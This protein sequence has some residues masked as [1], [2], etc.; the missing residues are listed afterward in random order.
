MKTPHTDIKPKY[1]DISLSLLGYSSDG[2]IISAVAYLLRSNG[3]SAEE[4][5]EFRSEATS[6]DYYTFLRTVLAWVRVSEFTSD[7]IACLE[8]GDD[9]EGWKNRHCGWCEEIHE[10]CDCQ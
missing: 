8:Q 4:I 3:V 6:D 9:P 5:A 10:D 1:D 7:D 2:P